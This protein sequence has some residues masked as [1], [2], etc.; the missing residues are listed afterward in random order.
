M[1]RLSPRRAE[2]GA[3]PDAALA[4]R[5]PDRTGLLGEPALVLLVGRLAAVLAGLPAADEH[6]AGEALLAPAG[7]TSLMTG[8]CSRRRGTTH[9]MDEVPRPEYSRDDV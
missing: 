3:R 4:A 9:G 1:I 6:D 5:H 2:V 7:A 8:H